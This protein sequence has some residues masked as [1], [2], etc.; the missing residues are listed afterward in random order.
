[1]SVNYV[2]LGYDCS[3]A[4]ALRE[5]NLREFALP[6][7]WVV[8]N[9]FSLEMCFKTNFHYFHKN[10]IF[11]NSHK[12]LID[13]YGFQFPHD[14]PLNDMNNIDNNNI[15]EGI[16]AEENGKYICDNWIDYYNTVLEKYN[17]RIIRFQN[18][19]NNTKP[20]IVLC[21][22][23]TNDVLQLQSL[24]ITYYNKNN[25]YFVNSSYEIFE[26]DKIINIHTEK[27]NIWN[28]T[29]IWNQGINNIL[30][31]INNNV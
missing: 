6:F 26:N 4:N 2:T 28:E 22:Y 29:E 15:G 10:L 9:I 8:S 24:L 27:N 23:P 12:R 13:I 5:L 20:V 7:D 30:V 3:P 31:K 11:N 14:Y 16:Y 17:R 21:R 25:V 18:I 19:M 1:M